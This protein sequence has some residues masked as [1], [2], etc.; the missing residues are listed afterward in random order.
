M[1]GERAKDDHAMEN[2]PWIL[3]WIPSSCICTIL[4]TRRTPD[5]IIDL[6]P[7]YTCRREDYSGHDVARST[8]SAVAYEYF[9][10]CCF[11]VIDLS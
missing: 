2:R 9:F 3:D 7:Q 4:P 1:R 6:E 8:E 5:I 10:L 11:S